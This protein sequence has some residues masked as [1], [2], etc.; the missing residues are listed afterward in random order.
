MEKGYYVPKVEELKIG[1]SIEIFQGT[2]EGKEVWS[3][4]EIDKELF[5]M[6]L[7]SGLIKSKELRVKFLDKAGIESLGFKHRPSRDWYHDY[8]LK[9]GST[10]VTLALFDTKEMS[11]FVRKEGMLD[12]S[13]EGILIKNISELKVLMNQL[14]IK[15]DG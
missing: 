6:V 1:L 2:A 5:D 13:A 14:N 4:G 15:K 3:I 7:F 11:I 12:K 9:T 10:V 8:E